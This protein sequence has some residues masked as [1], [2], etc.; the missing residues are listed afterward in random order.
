LTN[1]S[2]PPFNPELT[3]M[4]PLPKVVAVGY[5]RANCIGA[6][7]VQ[8]FVTGSNRFAAVVPLNATTSNSPPTSKILPSARAACPEQKRSLT[9][10]GAG[11]NVPVAG[12][13]K[14]AEVPPSPAPPSHMSTSPVRKSDM[15]TATS[16]HGN[17]PA[18]WPAAR[19]PSFTEVAKT[20]LSIPRVQ[21][22]ENSTDINS[23]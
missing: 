22:A 8:V 17:G 18:H 21:P 14:R 1:P 6:A 23:D 12:C 13:H 7:E 11:L 19:G 15:L 9:L 4:F 5:Q 10:F 16:G 3:R 20:I 2:G